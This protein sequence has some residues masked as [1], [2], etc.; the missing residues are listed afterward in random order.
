M[1]ALI[2]FLALIIAICSDMYC[3]MTQHLLGPV[4]AYKGQ[5]ANTK[6]PYL[7]YTPKDLTVHPTRRYPVIITYHGIG[8][9]TELYSTMSSVSTGDLPDLL[10]SG[11]GLPPYY[12]TATSALSGK[13]WKIPGSTFGDWRDSTE[14]WVYSPQCWQGYSFFYP[15]YTVRMLEVI[16]AN[17]NV[18]TNR[19]YMVG[20]SFGGGAILT[21]LQ[22]KFIS[23]QIAG[24]FESCA[25][26]SRYTWAD[27]DSSNYLSF[28]DWNGYLLAMHSRNDSTTDP[29]LMCCPRGD[30]SWHTT[31]AV[32]SLNNRAKSKTTVEYYNY[33]TGSH[34]IWDRAYNPLNAATN[35]S[36]YNGQ[37]MN[38]SVP[39]Q[40]RLLRYTNAQNRRQ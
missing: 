11:T 36:L 24:A 13:K 6:I 7:M 14:F 3:Q 27:P 40:E 39:F 23:D 25:G 20:L 37:T 33:T 22:D 9:R 15:I 32:D 19:I 38:W 18:D 30:G 4:A 5:H 8:E 12:S 17:P 26:Y 31:R 16:K 34:V 10:I 35:Y 2:L 1:K 28:G 29:V 21:H